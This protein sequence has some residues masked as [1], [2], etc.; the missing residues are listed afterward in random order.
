MDYNT[1]RNYY[2]PYNVKT[3][4]IGESYPKGGT[5]FYKEN[6]N[7]YKYTKRA[8]EIVDIKFSLEYFKQLGCWLYD[9]CDIP[10][11]GLAHHERREQIKL[12]L[13]RLISTIKEH[14][15]KYIIV[16][17][18]GDMREIV[19]KSICKYGYIEQVN[20]FN[21]PFPA[22]GR[23]IEYCNEISAIIRKIYN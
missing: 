2:K 10:V 15:P 14:N 5:F 21:V 20:A 11:N 8:F 18:K 17:K 9:V 3:L 12:G 16:V 4:V 23:Q 6:S 22:C 7:L 1:I 13:P 19:F